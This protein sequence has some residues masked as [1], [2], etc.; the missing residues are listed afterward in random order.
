MIS[1]SGALSAVM[2]LPPRAGSRPRTTPT[3]PH[4]QLDQQ[5][6]DSGIRGRLVAALS[7][8]P[9]TRWGPSA[10]SVP[11]AEALFL[12]EGAADGPA[13][14]FLIGREFAHLH[15]APDFSVHAMLPP[16]LADIL[17]ERGWAEPHPVAR[18]G[19]I[20][21]NAVMVYAPRDD[22]E[23]ALVEAV[24]TASHHYAAGTTG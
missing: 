19:L 24:V 5:P 15:P 13:D 4:T 23:R 6:Q 21:P 16:G 2:E 20:P 17:V 12:E 1:D 8:L 18:L 14:A 11:G 10:I 22:R 9:N 3:N 7:Q